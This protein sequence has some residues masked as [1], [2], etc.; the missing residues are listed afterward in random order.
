MTPQLPQSRRR[1]RPIG[2]RVLPPER[3][4]DLYRSLAS[5]IRPEV[6]ERNLTNC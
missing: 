1:S 2:S 3:A 6:F 4:A 5:H